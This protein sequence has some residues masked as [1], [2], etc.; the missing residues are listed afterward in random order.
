M[1]GGLQVVH[2]ERQRRHAH[3]ASQAASQRPCSGGPGIK[4]TPL[5]HQQG[6]CRSP[7]AAGLRPVSRN[8]AHGPGPV[9]GTPQGPAKN[10]HHR[11]ATPCPLFMTHYIIIIIH[12]T[13]QQAT[14]ILDTSPDL[15]Q[16]QL[17]HLHGTQPAV[18]GRVS[19][20][21]QLSKVTSTSSTR[22]EGLALFSQETLGGQVRNHDRPETHRWAVPRWCP[23]FH[24][25]ASDPQAGNEPRELLRTRG[26]CCA[27][28]NSMAKML[29]RPCPTPILQKD[30]VRLRGSGPRAKLWGPKPCSHSCQQAVWFHSTSRARPTG[31][32][33][34]LL[35]TCH[36]TGV[37]LPS[38]ISQEAPE[39]TDPDMPGAQLLCHAGGSVGLTLAQPEGRLPWAWTPLTG[40]LQAGT[41]AWS[42]MCPPT[43]T[44][45]VPG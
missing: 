38:S 1:S 41:L 26:G 3:C 36:L 14:N 44:H 7:S 37:T 10:P 29:S 45:T 17:S 34:T 25:P 42:E 2:L 31:E 30:K 23:S 19:S 18:K 33:P 24:I 39:G 4:L 32:H 12:R 9:P 20:T 6:T 11:P 43:S 40:Y 28:L 27:Q 15:G 8:A 21:L 35:P 16:A 13:P 22:A 5:H